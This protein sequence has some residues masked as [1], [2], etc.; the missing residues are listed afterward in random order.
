M[1][2]QAATAV[3]HVAAQNGVWSLGNFGGVPPKSAMMYHQ[4]GVSPVPGDASSNPNVQ[5]Q[6]AQDGTVLPN[7]IDTPDYRFVFNSCTVGMVSTVAC[8]KNS[9]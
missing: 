5:Q 4:P 7:K 1:G 9:M 3:R 6:Q 8:F 2:Q